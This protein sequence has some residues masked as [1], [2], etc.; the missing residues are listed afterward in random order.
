MAG[1]WQSY[2]SLSSRKWV[3]VHRPRVLA[4]DRCEWLLYFEYTS[5]Y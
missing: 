2:Y 1:L 3:I 4:P 5:R